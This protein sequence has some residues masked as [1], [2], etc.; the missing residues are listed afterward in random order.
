VNLHSPARKLREH[1]D[2]DQLK[3]QAKELLQSYLEGNAEARREVES[4]YR[5]AD[6]A[7]FA[8]HDAQL[9]LA[10]SYG[11]ESWPKLKAY[12][13]GMT[14]QRLAELVRAGDLSQ[15]HS[16]LRVRPELAN[17]AMSYGD[18][19]RPLHFAVMQRLP[20]MA[21]LLMQYGADARCGIHP[22]RDATTALRLA[23]ERGYDEIVAVIEEEEQ[24]RREAMSSAGAEVTSSQDELSETIGE[25]D[26]ARAIAMLQANPA[27]LQASDRDGWTP[28]HIAAAVRN[29]KMVGWLLERGADPNRRG[30]DGRT[31]FDLAAS[32][33]RPIDPADFSRVAGMLRHAGADLTP[34]A[35]AALGEADWLRARQAEGA[36]INPITWGSGGL[37]TIAVRHNRPEIV[38]LLLDFGFDSAKAKASLTRRAFRFGSAPR[39]DGQNSPR[40]C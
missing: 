23:T 36:L 8:L 11:F 40:S 12:V 21:R 2:L 19:H 25:R 6:P 1:P 7:A 37:L 27:L 16:M 39:S 33:R 22:H 28:L 9:V 15:V 29:P 14:V 4:F 35:A 38:T 5:G 13:D 26:D 24:R 10:R 31:P 3:R 18:E 20:A 17:M 34:R 32:G 30:T